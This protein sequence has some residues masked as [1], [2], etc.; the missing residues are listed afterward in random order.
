LTP[1]RC[2]PSVAVP[3]PIPDPVSDVDAAPLDAESLDRI[4]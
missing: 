2:F 4:C 1:G 3:S